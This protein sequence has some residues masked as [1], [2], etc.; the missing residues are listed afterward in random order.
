MR[1]KIKLPSALKACGSLCPIGA[2][3]AKNARQLS[4]ISSP[5]VKIL[6]QLNAVPSQPSPTLT[7]HERNNII[8][9]RYAAGVSQAEL[10]RRFEISYQRVH[11]IVRD[12]QR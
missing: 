8:R 2:V 5:V 4:G 9:A 7:T 10:A 11:Q 6:A 3:G 12:K 1:G